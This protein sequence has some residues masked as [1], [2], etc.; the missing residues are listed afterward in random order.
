MVWQTCRSEW[1]I[2]AFLWLCHLPVCCNPEL[3]HSSPQDRR[4]LLG[5]GVVEQ[6]SP[7][8]PQQRR[9]RR[10]KR[11][12]MERNPKYKWN[13]RTLCSTTGA[14]S[15]PQVNL[16]RQAQSS[17]PTERTG[18]LIPC[19][20]TWGSHQRS[21]QLHLRWGPASKLTQ[22]WCYG[23]LIASIK[24][25]KKRGSQ[26][27][28]MDSSLSATLTGSESYIK[29]VRKG[30]CKEGRSFSELFIRIYLFVYCSLL[31]ACRRL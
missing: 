2:N 20:L 8:T 11:F 9:Q 25:K 3:V 31:K 21:Y 27:N 4:L 23:K 13:Y 24:K 19:C 18:K 22:V 5:S 6:K 17:V 26:P 14:D 16:F 12:I 30:G 15:S 1:E 29:K 28:D 7:Q 10:E